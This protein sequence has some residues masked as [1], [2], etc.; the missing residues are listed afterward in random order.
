MCEEVSCGNGVLTN[1]LSLQIPFGVHHS[2][3]FLVGFTDGTLRV[4]IHTANLLD[5][6]NHIKA[7]G[8]YIQDFP[9]KAN[10]NHGRCEF[11]DDLVNY[12]ESYRYTT[13][14]KWSDRDSAP[15]T[16]PE[17]IRKYDFTGSSAVLIPSIPGWLYLDSNKPKVGHLKLREAVRNHASSS[18]GNTP[19][20]VVCQFSSMGSL[21][22]KYLRDFLSSADASDRTGTGKNSYAPL[23]GRLKIVFPTADEVR[24]SVEG[25]AGGGS[26]P[27]DSK[28]VM[29][30]HLRKLYHR[31][32]SSTTTTPWD[33]GKNVPHIKTFY[34]YDSEGTGMQW[35]VL[36]SHNI[37]TSAWGQ[38]QKNNTKLFVRH[39][40]L[41]VFVSPK[42]LGNES[43]RLVPLGQHPPGPNEFG[44]PLPY[45]LHPE[46]YAP[47]DE[48][49]AWDKMYETTDRFGGRGLHDPASLMG[50]AQE[51]GFLDDDTNGFAAAA[52]PVRQP[53]GPGRVVGGQPEPLSADELRRRRL[54]AL[55]GGSSSA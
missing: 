12:L 21:T 17:L 20:H 7:Q 38:L 35:F 51:R 22:E 26:A 6:D 2:K 42:L 14:A 15:C 29:K 48:P 45:Q 16:L 30:P 13:K 41:G 5:G 10:A 18:S 24:T 3:F 19:G 28:N 23:D 40:E 11:E 46:P 44:L 32:S 54:E 31:W 25:Y 34:Q 8:A 55:A 9:L 33:L 39:W 47:N 37:S 49:W 4:V 1:F 43:G 53:V 52:E 50:A 36:S 27:A